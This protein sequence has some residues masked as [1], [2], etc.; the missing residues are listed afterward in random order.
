MKTM[1]LKHGGSNDETH[2]HSFEIGEGG[3]EKDE[4]TTD[5]EETDKQN[6]KAMR[7]YVL[8]WA[9]RRTTMLK[10]LPGQEHG[11]CTHELGIEKRLSPEVRVRKAQVHVGMCGCF[12]SSNTVPRGPRSKF[13]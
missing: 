12:R 5:V 10:R 1:L 7:G 2:K 9:K 13:H 6:K 3:R 8:G 11:R 4:R